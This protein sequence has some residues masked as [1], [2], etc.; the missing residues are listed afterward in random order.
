MIYIKME[1]LEIVKCSL[2]F[3][4]IIN[5]KKTHPCYVCKGKVSRIIPE[6]RILRPTFHRKSTYKINAE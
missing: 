6:F 2:E 4:Y 5:D 3:S 1:K